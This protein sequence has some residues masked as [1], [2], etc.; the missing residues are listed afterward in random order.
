M[1]MKKMV[2]VM[3]DF[4][5]Y[6]TKYISG[7]MSLRAPQ[8]ESLNRLENI[9]NN[10]DFTKQMNLQETL[11]KINKLYPT[12]TNFERDFASLTFALATGVGKTRLMGAFIAYLY[13]NFNIRNFF[14]VAPNTTIYEKLKLDLSYPSNPKY[15]FKGL[16]CFSQLPNVIT[17]DD[18]R[19][20]AINLYLSD[21][22][23]YIYNISKFDKENVKMKSISE[24]WGES[25][26]QELSK[27]NDLVLIMDESH[28]YRA[29][30]GLEALN[31][32]KP[33]LGLELTAT[34]FVKSG[35]KQI[36]F[37]NVV[38]E[39]SLAQAIEDGYVRTPYALTRTDIDFYNF[40]DEQLDK[41]M[42]SDGIANHEYIKQKLLI[43]AKNNNKKIVKPFILIVCKNIE[44]AK[45]IESY[46]T[47]AD[48]K[49]GYYKDKVITIHS[50]NTKAESDENLKKLLDVEKADNPIEIVIH[51]N[52]LKE[53]W[54]VN[55]LYTII[56]LRT[57]TSKILREQMIGR[58]LRLPYGERT[59]DKEIDS[60]VLTAHDK[61]KDILE[62]AQ[63]GDSIFNAKNIIRA[64]DLSKPKEQI[65]QLNLNFNNDVDKMKKSFNTDKPNKTVE[66]LYN[67]IR[68]KVNEH[69]EK[70]NAKPLSQQE[71]TILAQNII[72]ET[73]KKDLGETF[74]ENKEP[75]IALTDTMIDK[76]YNETIKKYIPIPHI[77]IT[78]HGAQDYK[79]ADFDLSLDEFNHVPIENK[80]L[81]QNLKDVKDTSYIPGQSINFEEYNPKKEL[82]SLLREKPE[83]DYETV[84]DLLF[85]LINQV[86]QHYANSYGELNT[87]NIIMMYKRDI[88]NK[89]YN[90]MM[91]HFSCKTGFIEETVSYVSNYNLKQTYT[92]SYEHSLYDEYK[93]NIKS[94]LFTDIS[95]GVFS[96]AKF[97]SH[98]ELQ[99]ARIIE[100]DS[101]V[102]NWLRPA[103]KEF[104]I[105]YDNGKRYIPDFVVET[106]N[107]CY[108]IEIKGED[109]INNLDVIAKRNRAVT[110]CEVASNWAKANNYKTWKHLFI[111]AN[112]VQPNIRFEHLAKRFLCDTITK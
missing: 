107:L 2:N 53:G 16:G 63:K 28:N 99:F 11:M 98:P 80:I 34:P 72:A 31:D 48:F 40:G 88:T 86:Y 102:K 33:L 110:Y 61:F 90:Q 15:V 42:I 25:F 56:P 45:W 75:L 10:I 22:N 111:P 38:Y 92:Y 82:V 60:V 29:K 91:K 57:A 112:D 84:S 43:Y 26:Y 6:T 41:L 66:N 68:N 71:K 21:I 69:I 79:F 105:T 47:S 32:L 39:Y 27:L 17:D 37:K 76:I 18:Y 96:T 109:K 58:G 87:K 13:T 1:I 46:I 59:G 93:E 70:H 100:N 74:F 35:S 97:D 83:I 81:I 7:V 62:E 4:S 104:N 73:E 103:N 30:K 23:I 95:K 67:N 44:H 55:N 8:Q 94:I 19:N 64:E 101:T 14:V 54:D 50:K 24:Y 52:S 3:N 77:K 51:V 12:C 5:F 65:T 9:V 85:K 78:E 106:E 49:D 20:K 36:P 108:L 89:I